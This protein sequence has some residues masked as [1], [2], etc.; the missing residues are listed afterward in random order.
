MK[1]TNGFTL[2]ELMITVAVVGILAAIAYPSFTEYFFKGRRVDAKMSL[3]S[4]A[5]ELERH[6]TMNNTYLDTPQN[7]AP[8]INGKKS[9]DGNYDMSFVGQPTANAYAIQA[10]PTGKQTGDKCGTYALDNLG[11]KTVSGGVLDS[12][13]CWKQ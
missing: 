5:Q 12:A 7:K 9:E 3:M 4:A 8:Q 6:Y 13:T 11:N 10:T 1:H 2:I